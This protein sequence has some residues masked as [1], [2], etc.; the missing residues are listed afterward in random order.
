MIHHDVRLMLHS[1]PI[2]QTQLFLSPTVL[3][4]LIFISVDLLSFPFL[5]IVLSFLTYSDPQQIFVI[6][7]HNRVVT[8]IFPGIIS[9]Q[10]FKVYLSKTIERRWNIITKFSFKHCLSFPFLFF[11]QNSLYSYFIVLEKYTVQPVSCHM[12]V[13]HSSVP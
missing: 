9:Q 12:N 3:P 10:S 6:L 8:T 4:T 5:F 1:I 13:T 2:T 11:L 7:L